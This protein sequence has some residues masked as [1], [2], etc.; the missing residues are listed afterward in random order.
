LPSEAADTLVERVERIALNLDRFTIDDPHVEPT[1]RRTK[2]AGGLDPGFVKR[3]SR[4][5]PATLN[6]WRSS[7]LQQ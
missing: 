2:G 6:S 5:G 4:Y 3:G 7:M 1:A